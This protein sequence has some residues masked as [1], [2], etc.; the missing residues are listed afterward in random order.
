LFVDEAARFNASMEIFL[1]QKA[2]WG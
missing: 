1:S 2:A